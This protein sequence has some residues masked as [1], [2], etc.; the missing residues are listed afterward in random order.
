MEASVLMPAEERPLGILHSPKRATRAVFA[1]VVF[2]LLLTRPGASTAPAMSSDLLMTATGAKR[3]ARTEALRRRRVEP[4]T[5]SSLEADAVSGYCSAG[6]SVTSEPVLPSVSV[7]VREGEGKFPARSDDSGTGKVFTE[8]VRYSARRVEDECFAKSGDQPVHENLRASLPAGPP[9]S[10]SALSEDRRFSLLLE[11]R[12]KRYVWIAALCAACAMVSTGL[13]I[14]AFVT[15]VGTVFALFALVVVSTFLACVGTAVAGIACV[16]LGA[17]SALVLS[18]GACAVSYEV[19]LAVWRF[20]QGR[21][22]CALGCI[23]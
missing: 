4:A 7:G 23:V 21:T 13:V 12:P 11:G 14:A 2:A 6:S 10:L 8:G 22:Q 17:G 16:G 9:S 3:R 20:A 18:F 1:V 5:K 15:A 19:F